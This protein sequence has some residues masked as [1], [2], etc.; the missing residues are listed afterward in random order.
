MNTHRLTGPP[1]SRRRR[2]YFPFAALLATCL[3]H[4]R[5]GAEPPP[6]P[7]LVAAAPDGCAW[8]I[9]VQQ[10]KPRP[11]PPTDPKWVYAY[12]RALEI[13]PRILRVTDVKSGKDRLEETSYENGKT[14]TL[15]IYNG[16]VVYQPMNWPA[17]KALAMPVNYRDSPVKG[18]LGSDFPDV[19][20]IR[21]EVFAGTVMYEGQ[22]CHYYEDKNASPVSGGDHL[23]PAKT[24]GVRAWIDAR[25]R[26]PI[27]VE[28][29]AVFKKY[30]YSQSAVTIQLEGVF[31]KAYQDAIA[32]KKP[33]KVQEPSYR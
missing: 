1:G 25:T 13:Y 15:Y 10:K 29:E 22:R 18:G 19:G 23:N 8:T 5:L 4:L 7:P 27:A 33:G 21:P 3:F 9:D 32:G 31:A 11:S 12:K 2:G 17:D 26:L 16:Y 24:K 28:D 14:G 20:W 30:T 6:D